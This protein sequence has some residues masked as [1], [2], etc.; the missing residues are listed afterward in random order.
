[1]SRFSKVSSFWTGRFRYDALRR[2]LM[3]LV[4]DISN[5]ER[6]VPFKNDDYLLT[7]TSS[8]RRVKSI[9]RITKFR[10]HCKNKMRQGNCYS[11]RMAKPFFGGCKC[12]IVIDIMSTQCSSWEFLRNSIMRRNHAQLL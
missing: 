6:K 10:N 3:S 7:E 5:D 2:Y 11:S 8:F 1:M 12:Y 9:S 4:R